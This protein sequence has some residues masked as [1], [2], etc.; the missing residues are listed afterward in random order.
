[1]TTIESVPGE[2]Q[3]LKPG[4]T[5]AQY[6]ASKA[7][8]AQTPTHE[9]EYIR[10][11]VTIHNGRP[12]SAE[13]TL[14]KNGFR[15]V[16]HTSKVPDYRDD[17]ALEATYDA[18]IVAL[19]QEHIPSAAKVHVFDHTRRSSSPDTRTSQTMREPSSIIHND[20]SEWSANKRVRE[21]VGEE[22]VSKYSRFSIVNVWRPICPVVERW[23]MTFCDSETIVVDRDVHSVDRV[24]PDGRKGQVQLATHHPDH[25]WYYFPR[26]TPEE[27]VLLKTYDSSPDVNQYTIHSAFDEPHDD[28][29][30]PR[31]SM[32]TRAFV[33]YE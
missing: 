27:V 24:S 20:Y 12:R 28:S 23:P 13:W 8:D 6:I 16:S 3:Y 29:A 18:E 11:Q 25:T 9:G 21:L 7:G 17:K 2:L 22:E 5:S 15:L 26:M 10:Q 31:V 32:E 4:T 1:M 30:I 14:D 19:L 33:F